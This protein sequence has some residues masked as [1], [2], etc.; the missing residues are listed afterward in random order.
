MAVRL[1]LVYSVRLRFL[2]SPWIWFLASLKVLKLV[3]SLA[4]ACLDSPLLQSE[5]YS[6]DIFAHGRFIFYNACV[7]DYQFTYYQ[8]YISFNIIRVMK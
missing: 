1:V 3:D 5:L 6:R 7:G 4:R 2:L 8:L